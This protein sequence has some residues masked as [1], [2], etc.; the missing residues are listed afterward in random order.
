MTGIW[1]W[2][3][4]SN[5]KAHKTKFETDTRKFEVCTK[6]SQFEENFAALKEKCEFATISGLDNILADYTKGE[7][8]EPKLMD[9]IDNLFKMLEEQRSEGVQ[10][11][12][13]PLIPWKKHSEIVRR[14]GVD[15]IKNIRKKYPGIPFSTRPSS[16]RFNKDGVHLDDRSSLKM[17]KATF[18][19][20]QDLF[21]VDA[22]ISDHS[23]AEDSDTSMN[24]IDSSEEIEIIG[25]KLR[26]RDWSED[27]D[28]DNGSQQQRHSI[29]DHKF[30]KIFEE[31]K[32]IRSDMDD[33][34]ELDLIVHAGTKED[35][36]KI[37]NNQNMN[38]V[39]ISGLE[40]SEIWDQENWK[41]R[42]AHIKDAVTELFKFIDPD[43]DYNLG[44]VKHLNQRLHA[45]RQIVEVTLD[46]EKH[47]RGIRKCLA[48]K[49]KS[50]KENKTFPEKMN[51]VSISP[52]LTVATRVRIAILRAIS[53][54]IRTDMPNHDSWVIQHAARPVLKIEITLEDNRK[55]ENSYGFAQAIAFMI[56]EMPDR[57]LSD[58]DLFDAYTIAGTRFG[59]EISHNFVLLNYK[60]SL[61]I[62][63]NKMKKGFKKNQKQAAN[64][65]LSK[66]TF[67]KK[68][69]QPKGSKPGSKPSGKQ[70]GPSLPSGAKAGSSKAQMKQ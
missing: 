37:E 35:L 63:A 58:Q 47:G 46:S 67:Q 39:I 10:I 2:L 51:G 50:W 57:K 18:S 4:S 25:A 23:T 19:A 45:A 27:I 52:S 28:A 30:A 17:F 11:M 34:W 53:K 26:N 38:K 32:K 44:Y 56:K 62:L 36:D 43:R 60:T 40:V 3:G 64:E 22:A 1:L 31:I 5:S 68:S 55:A 49:I 41:G 21:G 33:R 15:A 54:V 65:D 61:G 69:F 6:A 24:E 13:E 12:V 48:G 7:W 70:T 29:H 59:P 14:A 8:D 16:L 42:V 20:S 66:K 9:T